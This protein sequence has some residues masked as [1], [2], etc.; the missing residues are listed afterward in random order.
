L[1]SGIKLGLVLGLAHFTFFVTLAVCRSPQA[2]ILPK[3]FYQKH[4][5]VGNVT[6]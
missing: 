4:A 6:D 1:G 3:A 2:H 5:F